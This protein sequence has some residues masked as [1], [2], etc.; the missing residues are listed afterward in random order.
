[1][2][3]HTTITGTMGNTTDKDYF[4]VTLAAGQTIK[5][6]M[7]GP[8]GL[9]YDLYLVDASGTDLAWSEGNTSTESLTWKNGTSAVTVYI[10][11]VSYSGSSTTQPYTLTVSY[12]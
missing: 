11:V 8:A 12:P 6:G 4:K 3:T 1:V 9:D 7:T 10:E 5:V 2:G